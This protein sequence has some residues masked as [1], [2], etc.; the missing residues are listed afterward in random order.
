MIGAAELSKLAEE[1]EE[2]GNK[3]DKDKTSKM[4]PLLLKMYN[5]CGDH[6]VRD[7]VEEVVGADKK[8]VPKQEMTD[9]LWIDAMKTLKEFSGNMDYENAALILD[10]V[11]GYELDEHMSELIDNLS[12]LV[13]ELNWD[14]AKEIIDAE[15]EKAA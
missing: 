6:T 7:R 13:N 9:E 8:K 14:E 11:R 15:L 3:R 2:A 1:L 5:S 4:T 12:V 10:S